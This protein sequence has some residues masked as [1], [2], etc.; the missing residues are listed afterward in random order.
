MPVR[1]SRTSSLASRPPRLTPGRGS[2]A[3]F[4]QKKIGDV[5][6][7]WENEAALEVAETPG[8]LEIIYPPVSIRAEPFVAVVDA[9]VD[10]KGTRQAA[11][12]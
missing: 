11:I 4:A 12:A 2:T 10:R 6:L 5:H 8:E 1:T 9:N 7:T 3:T